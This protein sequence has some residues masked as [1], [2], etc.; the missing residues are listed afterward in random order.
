MSHKSTNPDKLLIDK[1]LDI[2]SIQKKRKAYFELMDRKDS[3]DSTF[4]FSPENI[5]RLESVNRLL[6]LKS[7]QAYE[8]AQKMEKHILKEMTSESSFISDF[9]IDFELHLFAETKYA[10]IE[11]M[12]G[13]PFFSYRPMLFT[14]AKKPDFDPNKYCWLMDNNHNEYQHWGTHPL[15]NQFH[16]AVFHELY[17]HSYLAWHDIIDIEEVWFEVLV[18]IQ[19]FSDT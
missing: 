13:N 17:H 10:H 4:N 1:A 3:L 15:K 16:C 2:S 19:N 14:F 8:Q 6:N 11:K 9:E 18:K 5:S 7:K 12:V